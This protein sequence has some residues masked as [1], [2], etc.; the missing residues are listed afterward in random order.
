MI[1]KDLPIGIKLMWDAPEP[2]PG[3][4]SVMQT[5][6][7]GRVCYPAIIVNRESYVKELGTKVRTGA[8][9]HWMGD[10]NEF[11]RLP[12]EEELKTLTWPNVNLKKNL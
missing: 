5:S 8:R 12:T 2:Y 3:Y 11:L 7:P 4:I 1:I 6:I 9:S 10:E